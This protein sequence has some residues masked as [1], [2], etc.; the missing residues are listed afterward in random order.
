[1]TCLA[2]QTSYAFALQAELW[3]QTRTYV[4]AKHLHTIALLQ[5]D[6][7]HTQ[8]WHMVQGPAK[9]RIPATVVWS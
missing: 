7:H 8:L 2:L 1:M 4:H 9:L 5:F 6:S 3:Q